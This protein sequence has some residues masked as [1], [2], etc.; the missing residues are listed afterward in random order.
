M[1]SELTN[2]AQLLASKKQF[3]QSE[4]CEQLHLSRR[5]LNYRLE[6]LNAILYSQGLEQIQTGSVFRISPEL[7]TRLK[8]LCREQKS[9]PASDLSRT[10]RMLWLFFSFFT[11]SNSYSLN[12]LAQ[13]LN[14]SRN[15]IINDIRC[16]EGAL[17]PFDLLV[18]RAPRQGHI[19]SG[20][21]NMIRKTAARQIM[22]STISSKDIR[23]LRTFLLEEELLDPD[24]C[25]SICRRLAHKHS[26][27]FADERLGMFVYVFLLMMSRVQN[28]P[29]GDSL[30]LPYALPTREKEF[31]CDLLQEY[32]LDNI[33]SGDFD[34]LV[35]WVLG[36]SIGDIEQ[37]S[38]D[39]TTLA[40]LTGQILNRFELLCGKRPLQEEEL[41]MRLFSHLRGAFYRLLGGI[42]LPHPLKKQ[43]QNEYSYL[44]C[45]TKRAVSAAENT[46][47][48]PFNED[49]LAY[50]TLHFASVYTNRS[51]LR[52][53]KVR[54]K[55]G[56]IPLSGPGSASLMEA[57][58]QEMF[59]EMD[60]CFLSPSQLKDAK[61]YDLVFM[62]PSC[63]VKPVLPCPIITISPVLSTQEKAF[64][65]REVNTLL[66]EEAGAPSIGMLIEAISRFARIYD[67]PSLRRSL[68]AMLGRSLSHPRQ[69]ALTL[70]DL[71]CLENIQTGCRADSWEEAIE[72]SYRPLLESGAITQD[73]VDHT[74]EA[75]H[76]SGPYCVIAPNVALAHANPKNG[77]LIP[78][79]ALSIFDTPVRF[80]A[81]G[82]DPVTIIFSLSSG[83]ETPDKPDHLPAMN[84]LLEL[85]EDPSFYEIAKQN[86]PK[87]L[88]AKL[89]EL[90]ADECKNAASHPLGS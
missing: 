55:A 40:F 11:Q 5:Q 27:R 83:E 1:E 28:H 90:S 44:Y 51:S 3:A 61:E 58:L 30:L 85:L 38:E 65:I 6:K 66:G 4:L 82:N 8:E 50:L 15:T 73:Y 63:S 34:H 71:A 78:G 43:I 77:S 39:I 86:D 89:C 16:L 26:V 29:L 52:Q 7:K 22:N 81:R 36:A 59:P 32:G 68:S 13:L 75:I 35:L 42:S 17:E 23:I 54:R 74:I 48:I 79:L 84:R 21:E 62:P 70:R 25:F 37:D 67:E 87:A 76:L 33:T 49:E 41:F 88:Y 9:Q 2:L 18:Q 69:K 80:Y 72:I 31:V 64:V 45:M 53:G 12:E 14:V 46:L 47:G 10:E 56:I 57:D 24:E 60:F 20:D 19:I